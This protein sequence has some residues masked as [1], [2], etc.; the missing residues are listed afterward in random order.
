VHAAP[1][2]KVYQLTKILKRIIGWTLATALAAV[3]TALIFVLVTRISFFFVNHYGIDPTPCELIRYGLKR[4]DTA[5]ALWRC[6]VRI[7][8]APIDRIAQ[9]LVNETSA[10]GFLSVVF[11]VMSLPFLVCCASIRR[12]KLD[13]TAAH[14]KSR[15]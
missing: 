1:P 9:R 3:A 15:I 10:T 5:Y 7:G 8:V 14:P 4:A 6:P 2:N 13:P 12:K 11:F